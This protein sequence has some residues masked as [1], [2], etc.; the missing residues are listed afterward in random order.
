VHVCV[1]VRVMGC[2]FERRTS[3]K[4]S[5][6]FCTYVKSPTGTGPSAVMLTSRMLRKSEV[7]LFGLSG[8]YLMVNIHDERAV[9]NGQYGEES[10]EDEEDI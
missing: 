8:A 3:R 9:T 1:R 7:V 10:K 6:F 4:V 2:T 5:D